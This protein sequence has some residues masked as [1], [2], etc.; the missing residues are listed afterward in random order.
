M[1]L[2]TTSVLEGKPRHSWRTNNLDPD[3]WKVIVDLIYTGYAVLSSK[4]H[5]LLDEV[6]GQMQCLKF[7]VLL[8]HLLK[9][10]RSWDK[11]ESWKKMLLAQLQSFQLDEHLCDFHLKMDG[12]GRMQQQ[13]QLLHSMVL[14]AQC[15][16]LR[17]K[18]NPGHYCI[19][20]L[21]VCGT[22]RKLWDYMLKFLYCGEVLVSR[23]DLDTLKLLACTLKILL[24]MKA[25][26]KA[27]EV[28]SRFVAG[29]DGVGPRSKGSDDE[30]VGLRGTGSDGGVGLG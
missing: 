19:F 10:D 15:E 30:W 3:V 4:R 13:T 22:S 14:L 28:S 6:L 21:H 29:N 27:E 16:L 2:Q 24:F 17:Q 20:T 11:G 23:K 1:L 18:I 12:N 8:N 9:P 5:S 7:D 25:L 26:S